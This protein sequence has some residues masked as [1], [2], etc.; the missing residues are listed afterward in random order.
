MTMAVATY[1][2]TRQ[3]V[4]ED[5]TVYCDASCVLHKLASCTC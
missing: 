5:T 3:G 1:R 2:Q 4:S